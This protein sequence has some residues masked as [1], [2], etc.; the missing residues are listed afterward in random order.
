MSSK[1]NVFF[2]ISGH[3]KTLK[4]A[5]E[6][7]LN[8][9][10]IITFFVIPSLVSGIG[11]YCD[12]PLNEALVSIL[13]NFGSIFTALLFSVLVLIYDQENKLLEQERDGAVINYLE[14]KKRVLKQLYF[15]ISYC[16]V[17]SMALVVTAT[18]GLIM[19]N[20]KILE[21]SVNSYFFAPICIFISL[22]LVFTILMI[23][24]RMHSLLTSN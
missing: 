20:Y 5:G 10:D 24:K 15:N 2:I 14:V 9:P 8:M 3:I 4:S 23:V 11:I 13:I 21:L 12:F 18:A 16:I 22:N 7:R 19:E 6:T 1:I 17:N